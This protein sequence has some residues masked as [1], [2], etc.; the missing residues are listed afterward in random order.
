M[1]AVVASPVVAAS[2]VVVAKPHPPVATVVVM[3]AVVDL[4][5]SLGCVPVWLVVVVV[6]PQ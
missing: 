3:P 6:V 1:L 5:C 4:A 2:P